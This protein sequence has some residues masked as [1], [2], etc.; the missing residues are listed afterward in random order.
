LDRNTF[1]HDNPTAITGYGIHRAAHPADNGI[2]NQE[3]GYPMKA[4][5]LEGG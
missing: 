2:G 1:Q 3:T 4:V 5:V